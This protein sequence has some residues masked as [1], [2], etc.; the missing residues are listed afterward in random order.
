MLHL[1]A[2]ETTSGGVGCSAFAR[3]AEKAARRQSPPPVRCREI[4][5]SRRCCRLSRA[6][7]SWSSAYA[8]TSR[9]R[10]LLDQAGPDDGACRRWAVG[11]GDRFATHSCR[12][13]RRQL[14]R[15]GDLLDDDPRGWTGAWSA[16][17]YQAFRIH[18]SVARESGG[19]SAASRVPPASR[20]CSA[21]SACSSRKPRGHSSSPP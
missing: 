5:T 3:G 20:I 10:L 11:G 16:C 2:V 18:G 4:G 17:R 9:A 12:R 21:S 8:L 6:G 14:R 15:R 19:R 7:F 13:D 1:Q